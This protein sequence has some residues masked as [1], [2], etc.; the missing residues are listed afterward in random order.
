MAYGSLR[1]MDM[2]RWS[3]YNA[4]D[5]AGTATNDP[6]TYVAEQR[7]QKVRTYIKVARKRIADSLFIADKTLE[8]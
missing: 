8:Q 6:Y 4:S 3:A 7:K 2:Q 1:S 5:I